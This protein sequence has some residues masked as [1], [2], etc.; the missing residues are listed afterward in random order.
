M[1]NVNVT[2]LAVCVCG[3]A[4]I[5]KG[6]RGDDEVEEEVDSYPERRLPGLGPPRLPQTPPPPP[7]G[8]LSPL[9]LGEGERSGTRVTNEEGTTGCVCL[10]G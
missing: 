10:N 8:S 3:I 5:K 1:V 2:D 4:W 7:P 6:A 9:L